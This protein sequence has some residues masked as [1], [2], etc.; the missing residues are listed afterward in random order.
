MRQ[1]WNGRGSDD[2]SV[3]EA[4][5]ERFGA[6]FPDAVGGWIPAPDLPNVELRSR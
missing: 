3:V 6:V 2:A 1:L 5:H 4:S